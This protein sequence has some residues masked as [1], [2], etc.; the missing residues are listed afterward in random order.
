MS[1]LAAKVISTADSQVGYHE[2]RSGGH[3]NNDQKYSDLVPGMDWSDFQAWCQT[4]QSWVAMEA[5][6]AELEPRTASCRTA[7][8]WF[9]DRD[10][11]S[12]YPAIGAQVYF[13][14]GGG[15]HVGR[16]YRYDQDTIWTIEGNTN[17]SGSV[18]G[19]GVYRKKHRRRDDYVYGYGMPAFPEGVTT[20]DPELE[21]KDGFHYAAT[22]DSPVE[23][24]G[25]S[26]PMGGASAVVEDHPARYRKTI[27]GLEYGYGADGPQV[28]KVGEAL[29]ARGFGDHYQEG[30]GPH[31]TDADTLN[32]AAYQRSLGY[33]GADADGVPGETSLRQLLGHLPGD[34]VSTVDLSRLRGAAYRN[35]PANGQPVTYAGVKPVERALVAEGLL[36]ASLADGHF[37]TATVKAY[38]A[39]QRSL[40]YRGR[41]ADGIPGLVSLRELGSRHGFDVKG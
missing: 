5:G 32:Y 20:A 22:A 27:G 16:V 11:F 4:F 30:P 10:R 39:W 2:G 9:K 17:T 6:S 34:S 15:S 1:G 38:A 21:G 26:H 41:D 28:T 31:W 19:D 40:G 7:C 36:D 37:G 8:G 12:Y 23:V 18:E 35:P 33:H 24:T 29:V 25:G 13:G 14:P 3:W